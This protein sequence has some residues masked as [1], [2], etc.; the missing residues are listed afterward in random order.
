MQREFEQGFGLADY[1][2]F[3]GHLSTYFGLGENY[4]VQLDVGRYLAQDW[5]GTLTIG[6]EFSNGWEVAAFA[7]ITDVSFDDF[8]EGSFDKGIRITIPIGWISGRQTRDA[9]TTTIRPILRDGG[10]R[11]N[12]RNRLYDVVA[13]LHK[14]AIEEDWGLFWR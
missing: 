7:T 10:A 5:G 4:D 8:G 6:R 13:P 2:V 3:T 1:D 14:N 9:Y 12:V 11:L